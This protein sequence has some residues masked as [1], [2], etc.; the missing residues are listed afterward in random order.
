MRELAPRTVQNVPDILS[1]SADD[2]LAA[3]LDNTGAHEEFLGAIPGVAH[4][5]RITLKDHRQR[6]RFTARGRSRGVAGLA[7]RQS[8]Q[9]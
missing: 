7:C 8:L 6:S 1:L 4:T 3:G 2:S 5:F 9:V